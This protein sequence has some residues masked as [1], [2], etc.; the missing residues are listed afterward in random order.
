M[1]HLDDKALELK[2]IDGLYEFVI[3]NCFFAGG[4]VRDVAR[5][6][7]PRDYDMFFRTEEA[8][9]KFI[10]QFSIKCEETSIG[11]FNYK[12]FQFIT[13]YT[14]TPTAVTKTFDWDVNMQWYDFTHKQTLET[15]GKVYLR[16]NVNARK[17]LSAF[18]RLPDMLSK[19][20]KI[21]KEEMLFVLF[22]IAQTC[23]VRAGADLS[24][25]FEFMSSGGGFI[26]SKKAESA[27]LRA[28]E[29]AIKR[30][31]LYKIL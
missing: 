23:P 4:A 1:K 24:S 3:E 11:N 9:E 15:T 5:G 14:G 20:Y 31:P 18:L 17:P 28:S 7:S 30:S 10:N 27:V 2:K 29:E 26:G 8:K 19:G 25:H 13:L 6:E 16:F 12:D 22:F 21:E